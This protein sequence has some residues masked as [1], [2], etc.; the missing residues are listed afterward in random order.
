M[1]CGRQRS[2]SPIG[3][4][5]VAIV[6]AIEHSLSSH[7]GRLAH[8]RCEQPGPLIV[9]GGFFGHAQG[10]S[11]QSA[12]HH[13]GASCYRILSQEGCQAMNIFRLDPFVRPE[14]MVKGPKLLIDY[15]KI[16]KNQKRNIRP[17]S[18][19]QLIHRL[20]RYAHFI[21]KPDIILIGKTDVLGRRRVHEEQEIVSG[22]SGWGS[23][24]QNAKAP[25]KALGIFV[26]YFACS[27]ARPVVS[28]Q[29]PEVSV[30]LRQY[31]V[32]LFPQKALPV[33]GGE[34]DFDFTS[35]V[36]FKTSE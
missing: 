24:D 10:E 17:P 25:R 26:Q 23:G 21:W 13:C 18:R 29:H 20:F 19:L 3:T 32:D 28:R 22:A 33:V 36:Q 15:P 1:N 2:A 12:I 16:G 27:V 34:K 30:I 5:H 11:N 7:D 31:R 8:C 14:G 9:H 35:G 4:N 6:L